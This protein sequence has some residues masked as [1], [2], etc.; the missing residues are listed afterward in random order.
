MHPAHMPKYY[1][2]ANYHR[3][4]TRI[5]FSLCKIGG[6]NKIMFVNHS[7]QS[8]SPPPSSI[9]AI[10]RAGKAPFTPVPTFPTLFPSQAQTP[11][12]WWS[13]FTKSLPNPDSEKIFVELSKAIETFPVDQ[14]KNDP[15]L[16]RI[17]L[18]YIETHW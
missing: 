7:I 16:L 10:R 12:D 6:E 5:S 18:T 1:F 9:T 8:N 14:H 13:H 17:W 15:F 4:R 11:E 2:S 3:G